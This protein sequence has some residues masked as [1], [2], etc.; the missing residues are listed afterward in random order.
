MMLNEEN[1][2]HVTLC[3]YIFNKNQDQNTFIKSNTIQRRK[4]ISNYIRKQ[5]L[6][7]TKMGGVIS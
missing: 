7:L 1:T 6:L 4:D 5:L 2:W 3:Y